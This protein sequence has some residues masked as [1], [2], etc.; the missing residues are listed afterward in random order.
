MH[1]S[2]EVLIA[3]PETLFAKLGGATDPHL[4]LVHGVPL[5]RQPNKPPTH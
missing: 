1:S 3:G 5:A 2:L 4:S